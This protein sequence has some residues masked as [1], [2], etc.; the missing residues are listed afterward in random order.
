[1]VKQLLLKVHFIKNNFNLINEIENN[2]IVLFE[3]TSYGNK[4]SLKRY[5]GYK[6]IV[7][8]FSPLNIR[9]PQITGYAKHFN[10][11]NKVI[12]FLVADKRLLKNTMKCRVKLKA[13]VKKNLIKSL[14]MT[15]NI[16]LL[17]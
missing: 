13:S 1:M 16:L 17:N 4:G 3:I 12:Y 15:I 2:K 11:E 8:I 9:L 6:H 7:G 14:C 10:G 5:I